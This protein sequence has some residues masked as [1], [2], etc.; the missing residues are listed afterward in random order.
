MRDSVRRRSTGTNSRESTRRPLRT[1]MA[2]AI[3]APVA[4]I[5]LSTCTTESV[6]RA[7]L[8]PPPAA[9]VATADGRAKAAARPSQPA[10]AP[11]PRR[12]QKASPAPEARPQS[13]TSKRPR[14]AGTTG[15]SSSPA[16]AP[17]LYDKVAAM[18]KA[19]AD[20]RDN[21]DRSYSKCL[22]V[23]GETRLNDGTK[24][25]GEMADAIATDIAGLYADH[26]RKHQIP[27]QVLRAFGNSSRPM[28][29][30]QELAQK[31]PRTALALIVA[32][33]RPRDDR[34]S[35]E[36]NELSRLEEDEPSKRVSARS[37]ELARILNNY[38]GATNPTKMAEL[39]EFLARRFW[40][41]KVAVG[42]NNY[43]SW[44]AGYGN[45]PE[46]T[47]VITIL[48]AQPLM[49]FLLTSTTSG[50]MDEFGINGPA[51]RDGR[52]AFRRD[53]SKS[54]RQ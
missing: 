32:A 3:M 39:D 47:R 29:E 22:K 14:K 40:N 4:L 37:N 50:A 43:A 44:S 21:G 45:N 20:Y 42:D 18:Q 30:V 19:W 36:Q 34:P 6:N 41:F 8:Q 12:E 31:A 54:L 52:T 1:R 48:H 25:F 17:N 23:I 15:V 46:K 11:E 13:K 33:Y 2:A 51:N 7:P 9:T 27:L 16:S 38:L 35:R 10:K 26:P 28:P 24:V 53:L 49:E 5:T